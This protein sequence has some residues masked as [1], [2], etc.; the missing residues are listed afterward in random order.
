MKSILILG[1]T[2]FV[3]KNLKEYFYKKKKYLILTP[4][5]SELDLLKEQSV[6]A[7]LEKNK[8]DVIFHCA[9]FS[10]K[11][12]QEEQDV[13]KK[14]LEM[15]LNLEKNKDKFQKMF[16]LGSGAE[17]DKTRD[18]VNAKEEDIG[19]NIPKSNYG[20][21]KYII[22]K[23]IENSSNIYNLRI[24]GMFG[25]YED[26]WTTFISNCCCKAIKNYPISIRKDTLFDYLW[27]D[28][29][30]KIADWAVEHE[31]K[32]HTYNVGSNRKI[33]LSELA[34]LVRKICNKN[35]EIIICNEGMGNEYTADSTRLLEEYGKDYVTPIETAVQQLYCWYERN[36]EIIDMRTLIYGEE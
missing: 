34:E 29:F 1:A 24:W 15:F 5:H 9:I 6:K 17:Y 32:Y 31:F 14:D 20:L 27:I 30:C 19:S 8:I 28:D 36:Q 26:W 7:Y 12:E 33:R 21:A 2:G 35:I 22:G 13:I 4:T 10:P 3:G 18:I 25:K 11:S 23:I 16:Y